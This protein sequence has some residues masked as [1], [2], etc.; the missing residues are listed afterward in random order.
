MWLFIGVVVVPVE[1]DGDQGED[2]D[3]HAQDLDERTELAHEGRQVPPLEQGCVELERDGEHRDR[4][5]GEGQVRDVHVGHRPHPPR[6]GNH[7]DHLQT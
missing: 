3:V 6:H 2:A 5:V 7:V 4:D 1:G